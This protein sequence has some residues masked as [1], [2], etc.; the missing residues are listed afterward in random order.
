MERIT[1]S[2]PGGELA[3]RVTGPSD[4]ERLLLLHG[5]PG[6][7]DSYL[8]PLIAE[9]DDTYRV[10]TYAQRAVPP[11]TAHGPFD[12]ATQSADAVAVLDALQWDRAI[13]LG[14]SWG[15][16]LLLH[17][18]AGFPDRLRAAVSVDGLGGV[19]DAGM[20]GFNDEMVRRLPDDA[21]AR[22]DSIERIEAE[23]PLTAEEQD[24]VLELAWTSYFPSPGAAT[25]FVPIATSIEAMEGSFPALMEALPSL[26]D[27]LADSP[28][29]TLLVHCAGGPM[30]AA[31][32][33]DTAAVMGPRGSVV[34]LPDVGHFP[35]LEQPGV[36]RR[37]VDEF[38][39]SGLG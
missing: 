23:R 5:G 28:V 7:S 16:H 37:L 2:V 11:S 25:P 31:A 15:G 6:M 35:W 4:G 32:L 20:E 22:Y 34:S 3:A 27:R 18:V 1:V 9:F 26:A 8:D 17:V 14:H 38:M 19:G 36:V 33:Q 21:R 10:A 24:E 12:M 30:P 39:T 13:V 29:P